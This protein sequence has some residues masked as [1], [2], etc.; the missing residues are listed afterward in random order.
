[1]DDSSKGT[2]LEGEQRSSFVVSR[3]S[4]GRGELKDQSEVAL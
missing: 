1:M 3:G 4:K 2:G